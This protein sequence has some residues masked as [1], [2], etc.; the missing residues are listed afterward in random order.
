MIP[1]L[2]VA[3]L[4]L[5]KIHHHF[6]LFFITYVH[7]L[8]TLTFLCLSILFCSV[9]IVPIPPFPSLFLISIIFWFPLSQPLLLQVLLIPSHLGPYSTLYTYASSS[10]SFSSPPPP[11][12][13]LSTAATISFLFLFFFFLLLLSLCSLI[14][15]LSFSYHFYP[16]SSDWYEL[17][18][19]CLGH[20][21][22]IETR[23][24]GFDPLQLLSLTIIYMLRPDCK[25]GPL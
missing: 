13:L 24:V 19:P 25:P 16:G 3:N 22:V 4:Q 15:S 8:Q 20:N 5:F 12:P 2:S 9:P 10:S 17:S 18:C 6:S 14:H 7:T 23:V 11:P 1:S 21:S